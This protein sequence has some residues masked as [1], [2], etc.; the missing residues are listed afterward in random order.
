M[1]DGELIDIGAL[2]ARIT[3]TD[4]GA[5]AEA[6]RLLDAKTKPRRSLG[7][8]EDLVCQLAAIR[9]VGS[10]PAHARRRRSS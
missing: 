6:Q 7:R 10:P 8:L 5:A 1:N 9:G 2:A 4:A 3:P